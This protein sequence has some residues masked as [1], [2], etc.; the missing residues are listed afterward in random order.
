MKG[1]FILLGIT[2]V[3]ILAV[4][5]AVLLGSGVQVAALSPVPNTTSASV[6]AGSTAAPSAA[7]SE[8][9]QVTSIPGGEPVREA[10]VLPQ[11]SVSASVSAPVS[12]SESESSGALHSGTVLEKP[13]PEQK[14]NPGQKPDPGL[15]KTSL[16]AFKVLN[17]TT[18]KVEEV[19][20][21]DYVRGAIAAEMP[22]TF[23]SEALKA[24]G[25]AALTYAFYHV[26]EQEANPDPLLLG[27]H[28]SAD[29]E[30]REGYMTE[31]AAKKFYGDN[32]RYNWDKVCEAADEAMKWVIL[33]NG[34]PIA[35]AYHAISAGSTESA[36]NI[37]EQPLPCLTAVDSS[38]DIL[39]K[40]YKSSVVLSQ[41]EIKERLK[42]TGVTLLPNPDTWLKVEQRSPSGYVTLVQVGSLQM[43]G[44]KLRNLL[45]LRSSCFQIER[46]GKD[47]LFL[48]NGY[49]HG[50]GLSQN[51]ADYMARQGNS[52]TEILNHYY[53]GGVLTRVMR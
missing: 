10:Q 47:F 17:R 41:N 19:Q 45:G 4:P 26:G 39:A 22:A 9:W 35:A 33:S 30:K 43:N 15:Y 36:E 5:V 25:V 51:G 18:G 44:N 14:P 34:E 48:V 23:H 1:D 49:G 31:K 8:S 16:K 50:A 21:L 11:A 29:P 32:W 13:V 38:W 53:P 40:G 3:A 12:S 52:F 27:A 37:W 46:Q 7:A 28:F 24:Q 42:D 20:L 6:S 2:G